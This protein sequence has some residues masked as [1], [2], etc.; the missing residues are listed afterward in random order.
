MSRRGGLRDLVAL[1]LVATLGLGAALAC[2]VVAIV[3]Q[4]SLDESRPADA[5]V[6]LGAAQYNGLPSAVFAARLQHAVELYHQG[7]ASVFV[8]TGG[9]L[10]GD[11][12]TEAETARAYALAHGVPKT[13]ILAEND[14]RNTL[15]SIAAVGAILRSHHLTSAV[16]VSDR[17]HMLRVLR[18]ATDQ[19][20]V[21]WGS[22]TPDSPT[23][24][25]PGSH[26][27]AILHELA[28]LAAYFI[29]GGQLIE[30]TAVTG[31]P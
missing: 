3:R 20:L 18:M 7:I 15:Q 5:I 22:P 17:T 23:D 28:G 16:F 2:T 11:R 1:L 6:V 9:K 14:G 24:L 25:D 30:D 4:G 8:V 13:A 10:P 29:G 21:A 26:G 19:G 27:R 31:T 12:Y